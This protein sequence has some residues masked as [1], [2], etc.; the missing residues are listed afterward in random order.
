MRCLVQALLVLTAPA[1]GAAQAAPA[2]DLGREVAARVA[3]L[4]APTRAERLAAQ[5]ALLALPDPAWPFVLRA[6]PPPGFE[7]AMALEYVKAHRP[8]APRPVSVPG[9]TYDVGSRAP[10]DQNPPRQVQLRAFRIDDVEVTCVEWWR[11]VRATGATPPME[12]FGGRY[13]YGGESQPVGNVEPAEAEQFAAWVG[14]RLPAADEWEV[15]A[16]AGT[17]RPYPW[18]EEFEGPPGTVAM[19]RLLSGGEPP[20]VAS[21]PEDRSPFGGFDFC[22]SLMEWVKLPDG[23]YAARGG[24]FFTGGK[25]LLRL[26]RAPDARQTRR[27]SSIGLRVVD[28][29]Q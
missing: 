26:T 16:H 8:R 14:G 29:R 21:A 12:W 9:G 27:R 20:D 4:A 10:L 19:R 28:R 23:K 2:E 22:A 5:E 6:A 3:A 13:R 11:F 7:P 1:H 24:S 15:A 25:E 18:G 17:R